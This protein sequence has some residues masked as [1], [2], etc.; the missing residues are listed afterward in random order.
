MQMYEIDLLREGLDLGNPNERVHFVNY[1]DANP[2][3]SSTFPRLVAGKVINAKLTLFCLDWNGFGR[4][5]FKPMQIH[6]LFALQIK[7]V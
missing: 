2:I 3:W 1:R 6:K 4:L 5:F 7:A